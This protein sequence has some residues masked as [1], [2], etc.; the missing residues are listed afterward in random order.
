M[1]KIWIN[2][3]KT[4]KKSDLKNLKKVKK[5]SEKCCYYYIYMVKYYVFKNKH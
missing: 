3:A 2:L 5:Y 4:L 1:D